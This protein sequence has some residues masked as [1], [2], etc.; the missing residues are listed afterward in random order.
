MHPKFAGDGKP[1]TYGRG[2]ARDKIDYILLSPAL[3][4]RVTGGSVWRKGVWGPNKKPPVGRLSGNEDAIS[5]GVRPRMPV[6]R[7]RR[8]STAE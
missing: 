8:L 4:E 7:P 6:R 3:Y 1:G 5:R 2:A